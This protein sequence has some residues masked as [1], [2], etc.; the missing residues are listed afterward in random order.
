MPAWKPASEAHAWP[1]NG[2]IFEPRTS[3][4]WLRTLK[5]KVVKV[6]VLA[7]RAT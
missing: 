6:I 3:S 1:I 2:S 5:T 7:E 4:G